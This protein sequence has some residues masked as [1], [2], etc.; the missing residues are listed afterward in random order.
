[1]IEAERKARGP[2]PPGPKGRPISGNFPEYSRDQLGFLT[3]CARKYGDVVRLRFFN[4][5]IVLL[6]HPDH[7]EQ[8]LVGNNRNFI[9][10]RA[11]RSGLRFLGSGL[12][13]S[14]GDFWRHQRRLAQ[15]AFRRERINAYG[16]TMVE[17]AGQMLETWQDGEV[18]DVAGEMSRLTLGIVAKTLFGAISDYE[19]ETVGSA[20]AVILDRFTGG[21]L[22]KVPERIP[23]PANLRFRRALRRLEGII[24]GIIARRHRDGGNSGDLLSMLLSTRDEETGEGMSDKQLRDEVMTILLAGHETTALNLVWTFYLLAEHPQAEAALLSELEEELGGRPPAVADVPRLRYA[25]AVVKES[26][27]LY[28]P[29]W[30]FGREALSACE[31][32]GYRVPAST[33]LI[34]SQWVTHRDGRFF[35]RAEEF[36]PQ[37]WL[38]GSTEKLPSYA[39]FPFGGG[40]RLCIGRSF[41]TLEAILLLA[42]ISQRFRLRPAYGAVAPRPSLSLRPEG[43]MR[44]VLEKR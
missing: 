41:A 34:V 19:R 10:D 43:G 21:V 17:D 14:E 44:V 8:V 18:R 1:M 12:L 5:G 25:G 7:I 26:L 15:P 3:R 4:V 27:R 38:D 11:E 13:T 16:E 35:D 20:L 40:P 2:L 6:N 29:A 22:F 32:G 42:T 33:Q 36:V 28:P 37:R 31:I 23:T 9:K 24:Y 30:G 39:Y